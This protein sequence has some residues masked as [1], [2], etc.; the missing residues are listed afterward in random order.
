MPRIFAIGDL[1][2]SLAV[3]NKSMDIFGPGWA[4]HIGRLTQGWQDTVGEGDLVLVP[5]DISWALRPEEALADLA[6]IH[7]LKGHKILLR[8]NHDYWW[9][10]YSKLQAM[11]PASMEAVQNNAV[12]W[13]DAVIGGTRGWNTPL[14]PD[15]SESKDRKIFEREKQ[16]Q[17]LSLTA[18]APGRLPIFMLHYPPFTEKGEPTDFARQLEDRGIAH[19]VYGHLHGKSCLGGFQGVYEGTEYHLTSADFLSFVPRLIQEL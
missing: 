10:G 6:F 13:K 9:T 19:C 12:V 3:E 2:L 14:S 17:L 15:F 18:M 1:H 4:G 5:G 16:R 11:L 8:G 7:S